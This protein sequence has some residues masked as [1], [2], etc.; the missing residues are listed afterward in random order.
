[1][2]KPLAI[3]IGLRYTRAKRKNH[4][5]SFI[6]LIAMG[7]IALGIMALITVLSVMNGFHQE[8]REQILGLAPHISIT[9]MG[10]EAGRV[11]NWHVLQQTL[12]Q[13]FPDLLTVAPVVDG[14]GML[15]SNG[16]SHYVSL[17]G[18]DPLLTIA[19]QKIIDH[20][21]AGALEDLQPGSY[22]M[23]IG[24]RMA[25]Y[26]H[27]NV[28]DSILAVTSATSITPAGIVPRTKRFTVAGI[29]AISR[30]YDA[31]LAF[32][33]IKDAQTIFRLGNSVSSLVAQVPD[34]YD[35][36]KLR[37]EIRDWLGSGYWVSD[38]TTTHGSFFSAIKLEKTMMFIILSLIIAVAAFN[39]LSTL[40][41]VVTDKQSD[42]AILRTLGAT[43][44]MIVQIFMTQ[45]CLIGIF[46]T[47]IGVVAGVLLS[48]NV[49][50][51]VAAIEA[52]FNRNF[53]AE[54]I[55]FLDHLPAVIEPS[56]V[57]KICGVGLLMSLVATLY[58]AWRASRTQP[59][60]ALRYE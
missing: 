13:Q 21:Q 41:M 8:I 11:D 7:G 2:F 20:M 53:I 12:T 37:T 58:P 43:P 49:T 24:Q 9:Q 15:T 34:L 35:S 5:I 19:R 3:F 32:I 48:L 17:N 51:I 39:I 56:D 42:I 16:R 47:L 14:Q 55:Y 38:W 36:P 45:G 33:N 31:N 46:G 50:E 54:N 44:N 52:Y 10:N 23:I 29:F 40:V 30:D 22:K 18:I 4:F 27:V 60:E 25:E 28:G 6:S 57:I 1:M 59:A 26:L